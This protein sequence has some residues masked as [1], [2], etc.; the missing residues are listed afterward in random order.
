VQVQVVEFVQLVF[1]LLVLVLVQVQEFVQ[2][3]VQLEQVH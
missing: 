3:E 1:Q 2:L